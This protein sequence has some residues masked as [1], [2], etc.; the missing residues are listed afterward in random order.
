MNLEL[1]TEMVSKSDDIEKMVSH[2]KEK[3]ADMTKEQLMDAI[4]EELEMLEYSP[5]DVSAM[6]TMIIKK[7]G[8]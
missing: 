5:K 8:K 2:W 4:G 6:I 7:L 3:A 1:I